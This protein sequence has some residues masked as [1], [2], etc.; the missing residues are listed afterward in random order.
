MQDAE[1]NY[2]IHDKEL[3]A[4]IQALKEWK[5]Y[6]RGSPTPIQVLTHYKNLVTFMP[7]KDLSERQARWQRFLSQ[8]NFKIKY[9]L[10][11]EG[12]KPDALTTRSGDQ[13]KTGDKRLT[14]NVGILL[15]KEQ[16]WY[17]PKGE[18]IKIEEMELAEFQAKDEE[19]IR[20]AYNKDNEI[21]AIR[22]N[23]ENNVK[24]MKGVALGLC[25]WKEK[26]HLWYQGKIWIPNDEELR[27]S[28]IRRNHD[29]PLAGHGATAKTTE[30]VG[31]Q[32]HWPKMRET[33]KLYVKNCDICQRSKVIRHAPYGMLQS[34]EDPD[35][36]SKSM[37][38]DFITDLPTSD[39]YDTVLVVIDRLTKMSHF[40]PCEKSLDAG[41]FATLFLKEIIRLHGIPREI[42]TD[43]GSLFTS[44]LWTKITEKLGIERRL[45]TAF[46]PQK[47]GE[48]EQTN[49]ILEQY[50][51]AYVNYQKD[52]WNELLPMA[53]FAYNN[54]YQETIKTRP[55]YANYGV[56]PE[57]QL[58]THMMT[59]K[60]TSATSIKKL[61]DIHQAEMAT[62]QLRHK[63]N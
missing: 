36:P 57:H 18:E 24:E 63:E 41:Q 39:G 48:T 30:L 13:P 38:M 47:D 45:S 35:Q 19:K 29:D 49:G 56:N 46:H 43:W 12:G 2:D 40:I 51:R 33:I 58:I 15:L 11:R 26:K 34:N 23:L 14:R 6:T 7:T 31:Q 16:Y 10:G 3:L 60:I 1:C 50:L 44:D 20:Q 32:Y 53:E 37:A 17:I 52:N 59:E 21:Q 22:K 25:E 28:L 5:R 9:Q 55:F 42:I 4:I 62:A 61:H 27:T 54:S 8:Y